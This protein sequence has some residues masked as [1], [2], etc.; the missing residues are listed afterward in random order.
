MEINNEMVNEISARLA[1]AEERL[2]HIASKGDETAERMRTMELA[3]TK[4][5]G[6]W[7]A[8]VLIAGAIWVLFQFAWDH[9][10]VRI[11]S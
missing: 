9:V 11:G 4:Y 1:R 10:K 6:F 8:F 3:L 5:Q 2:A 7:G